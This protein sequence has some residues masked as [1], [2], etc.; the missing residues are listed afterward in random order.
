[1]AA[2]AM[3]ADCEIEI[4]RGRNNGGVVATELEDR[5]GETGGEPRADCA[6]H[7]G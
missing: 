7:G 6:A 1:M 4:G 5:A 3:G 2:K